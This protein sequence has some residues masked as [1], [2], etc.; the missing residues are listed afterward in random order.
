MTVT[1][2]LLGARELWD[3]PEP[4]SA[5]R[6]PQSPVSRI[7]LR[8]QR[9][10]E[11]EPKEPMS[12][13]SPKAEPIQELPTRVPK[14]CIGDLDFSDL[15]EDEDQDTLN[16]A[17]AESEKPFSLLP[18]P[19]SSFSG[20]PPPP[21][22]PPPPI[23]GSCPPPPP[24]PPP[25]ILGSCPPPPPLA[26]PFPHSVLD[27]PSLPTKRKTVK[28]FWRELKLAGSPGYSRSRF[29]P[30]PTLW[31]S[32]E[33]VSVDTARLEH[34]FESR[35]KDVLP[36]KVNHLDGQNWD[37]RGAKFLKLVPHFPHGET[38]RKKICVRL[39]RNQQS[40]H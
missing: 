28:L 30:C 16:A 22:P 24:P 25:P 3:S 38:K 5:P 17:S 31:A 15:G 34:L 8:T 29:G 4:A 33:P 6:T 9:S 7:L 12:P 19:P 27:G 1:Y 39:S 26:A 18:Q 23:L 13:P 10:L 40:P 35:A 36:T 14:L 2:F 20:G 21:P 32:L 11:P 37:F